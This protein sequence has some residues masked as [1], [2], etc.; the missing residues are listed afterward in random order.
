[1]TTIELDKYFRSLLNLDE[2]ASMDPSLNGLQVDNDGADI[3]KC[4]FAVDACLETF[5]RA[6]EIGAGLVFVHHGLFWG[7]PLRIAGSHRL[8]VECLLKNNIA[9]YAVHIP[10]DQHREYGNNASLGRALG[11]T[12]L[13][14]FGEWRGK[15]VGWKGRLEKPLTTEEAAKLVCRDDVFHATV[16]P[17]GKPLNQTCAVISGGAANDVYQAMEEGID[18]YVTGET[19]H[20]VYHPVEEGKI[21]MIS[22][23]HYATEVYG[24]QNIMKKLAGDT[25]METEFIDLPTGL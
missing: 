21:N 13:E 15:K 16:L 1:M 22:A 6:A 4:A 11:L 2:F 25:G 7:E 24:V 18:L 10:L 5:R 19:S 12:E 20:S 17:F 14:P 8:R 23:G 9:L 3:K